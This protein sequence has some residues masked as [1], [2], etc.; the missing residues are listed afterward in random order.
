MT[1]RELTHEKTPG[2]ER[3]A[4]ARDRGRCGRR[5]IRRRVPGTSSD[6]RI[7][8]GRRVEY[9]ARRP[10]A[11]GRLLRSGYEVLDYKFL[12]CSYAILRRPDVPE[13]SR[14]DAFGQP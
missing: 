9:R 11:Y 7:V 13:W 4:R 8:G 3:G 1:N 6:M 2:T 10:H 14:W 5:A 12:C